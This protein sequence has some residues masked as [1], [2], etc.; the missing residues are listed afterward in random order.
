MDLYDHGQRKYGTGVVDSALGCAWSGVGAELRHH[1]AGDIPAFDLVQTEIGIAIASHPKAVVARQGNGVKQR[2]EAT[3]GRSGPARPACAK[4]RSHY[5][6]GTIAF[7]SISPP[8][9]STI[10]PTSSAVPRFARIT[11]DISRTST[12]I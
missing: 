11:S 8:L 5:T 12:T 9:G 1:P 10:C 4:R 6:N 3:P 2:T 7:T